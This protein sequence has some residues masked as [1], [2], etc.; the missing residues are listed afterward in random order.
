MRFP[1]LCSPK[2]EAPGDSHP[3]G[4]EG[5]LHARLLHAQVA[6]SS[7]PFSVAYFVRHGKTRLG[8]CSWV[9]GD[10]LAASGSWQPSIGVCG[11]VWG[12]FSQIANYMVSPRAS[13][14]WERGTGII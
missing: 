7:F 5:C 1:F 13:E 14:G 2:E 3:Y 6:G 9:L 12:W 8:G 4:S 11:C 10:V